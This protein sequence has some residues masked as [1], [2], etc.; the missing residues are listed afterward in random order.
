MTNRD[1]NAIIRQVFRNTCQQKGLY[2]CNT[3][4]FNDK[5]KYCRRRVFKSFDCPTDVWLHVL[6]VLHYLGITGWEL[7]KG[8]TSYSHYDTMTGIKKYEPI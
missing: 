5:H 2:V 4:Y 6:I 3:Y 7:Y 8:G 1:E